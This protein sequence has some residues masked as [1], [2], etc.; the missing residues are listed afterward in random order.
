[1][2]TEPQIRERRKEIAASLLAFR[3]ESRPSTAYEF[4]QAQHWFYCLS[5]VL[6][7]DRRADEAF[8]TWVERVAEET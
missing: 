6:G 2:M 1:M 4:Q 3:A 8:W 5:E 7:T